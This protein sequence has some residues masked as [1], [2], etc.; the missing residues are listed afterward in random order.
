MKKN[1]FLFFHFNL[2][3]SSVD[4]S[5]RKLIIKNCYYPILN[6]A[7]IYNIPINIE[8][9]ART[10]LEIQKIDKEFIKLL[11]KLIRV[12][13]IYFVGSGFNQIIAPLVPF[14]VTCKNLQIGNHYYKKILGKRP[15]T[16]LIN[17]MAFS[18]DIAEIYLNL[19]YK[20]IIIDYDNL[21]SSTKKNVIPN[22]CYLGSNNKKLNIIYASSFLFQQFQ[23]CIYG[24]VSISKYLDLIKRYQKSININLPIYSGDAEVFNFRAGRFF[25][26]RKKIHNEWLRVYKL[27]DNILE[28]TQIR[29]CLIDNLSGN[30]NGNK[31]YNA[32]PEAPITVKKQPKYNISRW[33]VTGRCDQKINTDCYKILQN[34]K[35]II[36]KIGSKKFY[37]NLLDLW[38]SD[39][40]THITN[41]RWIEYKKKIIFMLNFI[42]KKVRPK[43][44]NIFHKVI[45]SKEIYFDS[46]KT[47]LHINTL[48]IKIVLN[49]R[50]GLSIDTLAYKSQKFQPIIGTIHRHKTKSIYEGADFYSGN[51]THEILSPML[52]ITDLNNVLPKI[53]ENKDSIKIY[54]N[55]N[56][57][58]GKLIKTIEIKKKSETVIIDINYKSNKKNI[59]SLRLNNISFL[60]INKKKIKY[61][62]NNGGKIN[63]SYQLKDYFDQSVAPTKFVSIRNGLGCTDSKLSFMLDN[64]R[65][66][67]QWDN[68]ANYVLPAI[69]Y[70]KI[71]NQKILRVFFCNQEYD[72]T[73]Y[74]IK[75]SHNFKLKISTDKK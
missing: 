59:G 69:Q 53:Y 34:K 42:K 56:L 28:K 41:K 43:K 63:S 49:V 2:F 15:E 22:Y 12:R 65:I 21:N 75:S 1:S 54:S 46:E 71:N 72:E 58:Y 48:K 37:E 74:P 19:G 73:S 26:E 20:N 29:F 44:N 70:K 6:I 16:A 14:E 32:N 68:A 38:S 35:I 45:D 57:K 67:F 31:M 61:I 25:S 33:S 30:N 8:A 39:Y 47:L 50:R 60:N 3:F 18:K 4:K 24:D 11:N 62:C 27:L 52:K 55:Q 66:N 10:L 64:K 9:S 13:K 7:E 51:M 40:R 5:S 36:K 23:S 17:E